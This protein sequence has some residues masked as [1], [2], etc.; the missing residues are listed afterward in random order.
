MFKS[1]ETFTY[2]SWRPG[3]AGRKAARRLGYIKLAYKF[4]GSSYPRYLSSVPNILQ[5]SSS[6]PLGE[7]YHEK[8]TLG[9]H[10]PISK[11]NDI[12]FKKEVTVVW[13]MDGRMV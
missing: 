12:Q 2:D 4:I 1:P 6:I 10:A 3:Q 5:V 13:V 7:V 9:S 11:A 8:K